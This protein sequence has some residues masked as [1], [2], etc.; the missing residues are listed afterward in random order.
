MSVLGWR[1]GDF[2]PSGPP[3]PGVMKERSAFEAIS[4]GLGSGLFNAL[5]DALPWGKPTWQ[6][7]RVSPCGV[8]FSPPRS[9]RMR[10]EGGLRPEGRAP[11]G[12]RGL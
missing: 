3:L 10:G 1:G 2:A 7:E 5:M 8:G 6:G 11:W 12:W 4:W 9:P